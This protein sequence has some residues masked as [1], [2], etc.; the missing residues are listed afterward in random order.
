MSRSVWYFIE[1]KNDNG[2]WEDVNIYTKDENGEYKP[3]DWDTGNADW[4]LFDLI[5]EKFSGAYRRIPNDLGPAASALFDKD[6]AEDS[7]FNCNPRESY[8]TAWYDLI[9]LRLLEDSPQAIVPNDWYEEDNDEPEFVNGL[10]NFM[11]KIEL[12]LDANEIWYVEPGQ[13]RIIC[14]MC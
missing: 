1:K 6:P 12:I 2:E 3:Y 14:A 5:F 4:A 11:D 7:W 8:T 9:E 13:V 10:S